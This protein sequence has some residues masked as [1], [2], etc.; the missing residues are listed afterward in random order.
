[1]TAISC[2]IK[3]EFTAEDAARLAELEVVFAANGGRGVDDA[4]E[5]DALRSASKG[6]CGGQIQLSRKTFWS[7]DKEDG[8][9][10]QE[11]EGQ[12]D[13]WAIYCEHDHQLYGDNMDGVEFYPHDFPEKLLELFR[14]HPPSGA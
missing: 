14:D 10:Y 1:M 6:V 5:L 3:V 2:P 9:L 13:L 4:E 12:P 11:Q 7:L 8:F